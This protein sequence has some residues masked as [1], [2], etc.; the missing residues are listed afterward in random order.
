MITNII[1]RI[2][3]YFIFLAL[4][5]GC[6]LF[7]APPKVTPYTL[8]EHEVLQWFKHMQLENGLVPSSQ[9]SHVSL[10]DN[11]L[12][13]MVFMIYDEV[14]RAEAIFDFFLANLHSEFLADSGGFAQMRNRS[15][16]PIHSHTWMGD[17]AWLLIA[18]NN[19]RLLTGNNRYDSMASAITDW[20]LKLQNP[21]GSLFS[22]YQ[23]NQR[24]STVVTE[25]M[26]DA[27]NAVPGYF[28]FHKNILHYL[29]HN[30]WDKTIHSLTTGWNLFPYA[31]DIHPW[32]YCIFP[33]FPHETLLAADM[34]LVTL[35]TEFND[36]IITGYSFDLDKD[37]IWFEGVGQMAVAFHVAGFLPQANFYVEQLQKVLIPQNSMDSTLGIPY[38]SN[39]NSTRFGSDPLYKSEYTEPFASSNA[40]FLFA[41]KKFNPFA[42]ERNKAIPQTDVFW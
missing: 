22:G 39:G 29:Q 2:T 14:D 27:F 6:L 19:Y 25:G 37:N 11:A 40:W 8:G 23:N 28:D 5:T 21:D 12:A 20:L 17:N 18:L 38:A 10:Y 7:T 31:L 24:I 15:G 32:S 9:S 36:S 33:N 4:I 13:S 30:R 34:F 41:I 1:A 16:K 42:V 35:Q 26:L 3:L